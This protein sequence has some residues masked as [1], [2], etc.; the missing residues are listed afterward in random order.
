MKS[1]LAAILL[2]GS[3]IASSA[4]AAERHREAGAH[5]HGHGKVEIAMEGSELVIELHAPANDIVGFEHAAKSA[6]DKAAITTAQ[7]TLEDFSKVI[8]LPS[9]AGCRLTT[10]SA[11]LERE[12]DRSDHASFH[13]SYTFAC[14]KLSALSTISF[15][16]F[17]TFSRAEELDVAVISTKGQKSF[18]ATPKEPAIDLAGLN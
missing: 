2:L 7:K 9:D 17:E 15:K 10:A 4:F 18:E 1:I 11:E 6:E 14:D 12:A 13:A 8:I 5:Q 3:G 16:Y